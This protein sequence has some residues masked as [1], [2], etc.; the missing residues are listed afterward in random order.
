[1]TDPFLFYRELHL[2][3]NPTYRAPQDAVDSW[4]ELAEQVRAELAR[5]GFPV[6]VLSAEMPE[7][8]PVGGHVLVHQMEPFGVA[9]DWS[10][11][12]ERSR[13]FTEKVLNQEPEGLISYVS[14]AAEVIIRA[15]FGV[16]EE[17]GFRVLVDHQE[18]NSYLH[19]VLEAPKFPIT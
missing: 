19:R 15:M 1:M 13:S 3:D 10:A 14:V 9:L 16:L 7:S 6:T 8:E 5:M 17:A 4:R 2:A 12:V 11:P 18:R